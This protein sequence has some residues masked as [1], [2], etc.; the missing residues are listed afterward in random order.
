MTAK[1]LKTFCI[2][3]MNEMSDVDIIGSTYIEENT[4][5]KVGKEDLK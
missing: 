4:T 5:E 1:D 2:S 3:E